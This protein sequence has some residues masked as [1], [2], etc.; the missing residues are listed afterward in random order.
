MALD[1][2]AKDSNFELSLKKFFVDNLKTAEGIQVAFDRDWTTP[3]EGASRWVTVVIDT[4]IPDSIFKRM[5]RVICATR[6]DQEGIVL[7]A[8]RDTV[9]GYLTDSTQPDQTRR[10]PLYDCSLTPWVQ[11]GTMMVT[12]DPPSGNLRAPDGSKYKILPITLRWGAKF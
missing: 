10:I 11:V 6:Q 12:L 5:V 1:A 3:P 2:T 4:L 9:M 7:V 8:L